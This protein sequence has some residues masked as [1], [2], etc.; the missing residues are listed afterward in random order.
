MKEYR[1]IKND[2][3]DDEGSLVLTITGHAGSKKFIKQA[4]KVLANTLN[5]MERGKEASRIHAEKHS[6]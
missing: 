5:N 2:L 4:I 6:R 3:Y 1:A